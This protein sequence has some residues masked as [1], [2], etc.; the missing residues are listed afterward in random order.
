MA[1]GTILDAIEYIE[2]SQCAAMTMEK[3]VPIL[4]HQLIQPDLCICCAYGL[5]VVAQ[6]GGESFRGGAQVAVGVLQSVLSRLSNICDD[7]DDL[8]S[9]LNDNIVSSLLK[10]CVYRGEEIPVS[11]KKEIMNFVLSHLPCRAD[12]HEARAC[13]ELFVRL[14][15]TKD[16][17]IMES[18]LLPQVRVNCFFG[19]VMI[20]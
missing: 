6:Y 14:L 17:R 2:G 15:E 18:D 1:L 3:L 11:T 10:L 5:G 7:D 8:A 12:L 16:A 4:L 20:M 19:D 13:H 9:L